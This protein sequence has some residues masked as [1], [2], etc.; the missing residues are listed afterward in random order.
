MS[1]AIRRNQQ[2]TA[3]GGFGMRGLTQATRRMA[4]DHGYSCFCE[5]PSVAGFHPGG[6]QPASRPSGGGGYANKRAIGYA[7]TDLV[8]NDLY[9]LLPPE[10][11]KIAL[12]LF[13]SF[14]TG[15]ER[16]ERLSANGRLSFGGARTF[17]LIGLMGY[18]ISL[19]A[20]GQ[21]LPVILGFAVLGGFLMLSY[22]H[23]LEESKFAGFTSEVS[24][25]TT[26]VAAALVYREQFWIA[27]TLTEIGRAH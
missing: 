13:L 6:A 7:Y 26:Y 24:A 20:G 2:Y 21:I 15:L 1:K 10:G 9:R 22:R 27:T 11:L 14:L 19:L 23:K 5:L 3:F 25:L 4:A 12:V 16:E 17:P 8:L 18:G